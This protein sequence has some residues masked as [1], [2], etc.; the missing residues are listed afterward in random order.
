MS[1][2]TLG[3]GKAGHPCPGPIVSSLG[4][5]TQQYNG[6]LHPL[7]NSTIRGVRAV[8]IESYLPADEKL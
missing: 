3:D 8:R 1:E 6:Q 2:Q 4:L 5:P 7:L